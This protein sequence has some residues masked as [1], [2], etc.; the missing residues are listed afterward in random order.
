[1]KPEM[2]EFLEAAQLER[3]NRP[4]RVSVYALIADGIRMQIFPFGSA[5]PREI[6]L[7][8][9]LGVSRT[10]IREALMLLQED[11]LIV[12]QRGVGRFVA[13]ALPRTGLEELTPFERLLGDGVTNLDVECGEMILQLTTQFTTTYLDL[14]PTAN[15]WFRESV[16]RKDGFPVAIVQEHLPAGIY[17]QQASPE[18]AGVLEEVSQLPGTLL[19]GLLSEA[20]DAFTSARCTIAAGILG[21]SRAALLAQE[22]DT[23]ALILTQVVAC[24]DRPTYM[25][26][27]IIS[28][29]AGH[30]T[31]SQSI[32]FT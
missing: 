19:S 27:C 16:L 5:L 21:D 2:L 15:I 20:L 24:G 3:T 17:L 10:V 23:S 6:E 11:G 4:L 12:T 31:V 32:R 13:E 8:D 28:P 22:A 9:A 30:L 26:K 1:M 7:A 14:D 25:S 29:E 18:V